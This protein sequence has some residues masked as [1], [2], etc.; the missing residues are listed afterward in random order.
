RL[1][2]DIGLINVY[3]QIIGFEKTFLGGNASIGM[4]LPFNL[5]DARSG[6]TPGLSGTFADIGDLTVILKALLWE[7]RDRGLLL[8]AGV[9]VTVPTGPDSF[10]GVPSVV[11]GLHN[12]L[13]QP[14]LGS[15]WRRAN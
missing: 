13:G 4:R 1:G 3:R 5:L 11:G 15:L 7:D 10:A 8:S 14:Y 6:D 12:T 2:A 9:A